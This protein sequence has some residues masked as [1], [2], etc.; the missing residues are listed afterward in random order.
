MGRLIIRRHEL[1]GGGDVAGESLPV[2]LV[3]LSMA[4]PFGAE[5][6]EVFV[7]QFP[8]K[9]TTQRPLPV[10]FLDAVATQASTVQCLSSALPGSS[11][12]SMSPALKKRSTSKLIPPREMLRTRATIRVLSGWP[13]GL[14]VVSRSAAM[15]AQLRRSSGAICQ[16]DI[17][18][19]GVAAHQPPPECLGAFEHFLLS[20]QRG[21][22]RV[23]PHGA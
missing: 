7:I 12:V 20:A 4:F 21:R 1:K 2:T 16:A 17:P 14:M 18:G 3:F 9:I 13:A 23:S 8:R 11:M 22:H 6:R 5:T 15:R 10:C 19:I